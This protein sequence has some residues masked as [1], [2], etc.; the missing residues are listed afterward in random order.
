MDPKIVLLSWLLVRGPQEGF[1]FCDT[2]QKGS[3][4]YKI[5]PSK[6]LSSARFNS[7]MGNRLL[8]VGIGSGYVL[9]HSGHSLKRGS[10]Q[11][12]QSLGLRDE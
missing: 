2:V 7:L 9:M 6:S 8:D 4:F 11:L 1:L 10:V 12:Y 5:N 3:G